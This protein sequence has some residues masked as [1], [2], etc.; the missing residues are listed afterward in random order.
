MKKSVLVYFLLE[1]VF[2]LGCNLGG[3]D[4]GVLTSSNPYVEDITARMVRYMGYNNVTPIN[5]E[6]TISY[7]DMVIWMDVEPYYLSQDQS[8]GYQSLWACSPVYPNLNNE[9][10]ELKIVASLDFNDTI[11]AGTDMTEYFNFRTFDGVENVSNL[12][13]LNAYFQSDYYFFLSPGINLDKEKNLQ[14]D[15]RIILDNSRV[16]DLTTPRVKALVN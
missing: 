7:H 10:K 6:D 9:I 4:C 1:V 15:V 14:F 3:E 2:I 11:P 12:T 5:S 16:F 13:L 8:I